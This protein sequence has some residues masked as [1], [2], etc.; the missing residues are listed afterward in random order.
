M[1]QSPWRSVWQFNKKLNLLYHAA[2]P[3]LGICLR[4]IKCPHKDLYVTVH[5]NIYSNQNLGMFQMSIN[6]RMCVEYP[7]NGLLFDKE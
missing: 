3:L 4:E 5:S 1:V 6:L 2:V 7:Y